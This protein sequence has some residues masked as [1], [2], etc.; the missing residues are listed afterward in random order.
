MPK[1]E[2]PQAGYDSLLGAYLH[3]SQTGIGMIF[4][5]LNTVAANRLLDEE[6]TAE[7][8]R[9]PVHCHVDLCVLCVSA[10][11]S[12]SEAKIGRGVVKRVQNP[13]FLVPPVGLEVFR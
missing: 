8:Q 10:V 11:I 13:N 2:P 9:K 4:I 1:S 3:E 6:I 12:L 5:L 7:T